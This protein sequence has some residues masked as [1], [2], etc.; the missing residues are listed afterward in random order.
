MDG[1]EIQLVEKYQT[2]K[3]DDKKKPFYDKVMKIL[4]LSDEILD[5]KE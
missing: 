4:G 3:G 2:R 5:D 1:N